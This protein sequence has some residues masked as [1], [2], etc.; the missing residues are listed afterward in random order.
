MGVAAG[1]ALVGAVAGSFLPGR[2]RRGELVP[3]PA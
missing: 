3:V 2:G 1:V